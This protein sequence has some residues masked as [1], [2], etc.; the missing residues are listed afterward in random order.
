MP[1]DAIGFYDANAQTYATHG[2]VN[3]RLATFLSKVRRGGRILELGSGSG[4]DANAML[5]AGFTV[6]ATDGSRELAQIATQTLGQTVRVMRFEDLHAVDA[7]DGIYASASLL[8]VPLAD[9][10]TI[11]GA[12][13]QALVPGGIAWASF[14]SGEGE[15]MDRLGR[16][17]NYPDATGLRL[18][19]QNAA[20]WVRLD[21]EE[22]QGTGYDGEPTRWLAVTAV[23]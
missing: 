23:R 1:P 4:R 10:T 18:I 19:W 5:D 15:G 14:K 7:Y 21:L 6:D 22:W 12:V 3:P 16:Y 13:H 2:R 9:L 20:S 8:H 17:Y 11:I